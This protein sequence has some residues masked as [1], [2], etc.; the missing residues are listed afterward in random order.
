MRSKGRGQLIYQACSSPIRREAV[1]TM[2]KK[3]DKALKSLE[4]DVAKLRK[5]NDKLAKAIEKTRED[6]AAAYK[7]LRSLLEE[8]LPV[9]G[10]GPVAQEADSQDGD[11][12]PGATPAAVRRAEELGI[13]FSSTKG[14]GASGRILVKDV[15]AAASRN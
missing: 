15:E 12:K 9:Q 2:A 10:L 13:D 14:T 7:E 6:Q 8:W 4:K 1:T 3:K 5:R 11:E